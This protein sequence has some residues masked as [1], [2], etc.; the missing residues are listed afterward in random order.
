MILVANGASS[1][2]E[3]FSGK[4]TM[5]RGAGAGVKIVYFRRNYWRVILTRLF[6]DFFQ[7]ERA[8]GLILISCTILS[9]VITNFFPALYGDLWIIDVMGHDLIMLIND[10]LMTFFFLLIG[11]ELEREVYI[12][13]LSD[14]RNALLPLLAAIG[15]MAVPALI[16]FILNNENGDLRGIGIP[17]ATDIAFSLAILSLLGNRVPGS[18]KV[19]LTALAVIDDLGAIIIIAIFYTREM[20]WVSLSIALGIFVVLLGLN[21]LRVHNL[22]PYM[23]GGG[24]MWYFMLQSGV[25]ATITG[26]LLAF[27]IPFGSGDPASPSYRLQHVL[28]RPVAFL[29][30]PLF[31][32]ANTSI[33]ITSDF[34]VALGSAVSLGIMMGLFFGKSAGVFLFSWLA[35]KLKWCMLPD[36]IG[37]KHIFG[38]GLLAAI[39]FTMSIFIALLAFDDPGLIIQAKMAVMIVSVFAGMAGF[40]WLK[41]V[42][43]KT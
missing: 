41:N 30:L 20:D 7:S 11:L 16:Y 14:F 8:G 5:P 3:C 26:V 6:G 23:L 39:G 4:K 32:L 31:A 1:I 28:H 10:G 12:G 15:G 37:W 25:H 27:A 13:E 29:V 42:L 2:V 24:V 19:F 18:L 21:R 34:Y 9:L 43:A 36:D 35:V 22:I 38:A 33:D 17:M 40:F